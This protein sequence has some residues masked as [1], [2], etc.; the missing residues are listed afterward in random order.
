MCAQNFHHIHPSILFATSFPLP[1]VPTPPDRTCSSPFSM[2]EI[3]GEYFPISE[4][5]QMCFH[6]QIIANSFEKIKIHLNF[7][8]MYIIFRHTLVP[9]IL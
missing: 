2:F 1:L 3:M 7:K 9:S 8:K 5:K 6:M 4:Q